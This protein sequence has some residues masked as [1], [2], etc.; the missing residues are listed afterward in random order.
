[1]LFWLVA[2][3]MK[4]TLYGFLL[5]RLSSMKNHIFFGIVIILTLNPLMWK[6]W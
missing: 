4:L 1:M 5:L 6:I 2:I 3:E